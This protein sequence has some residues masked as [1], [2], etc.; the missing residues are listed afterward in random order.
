MRPPG[1]GGAATERLAAATT[2]ALH[3]DIACSR[4]ARDGHE[5]LAAGAGGSGIAD[6]D[7]TEAVRLRHR[8]RD[9]TSGLA[10]A[11]PRV[12]ARPRI[13]SRDGAHGPLAVAQR[14]GARR[15]CR[16]RQVPPHHP[17]PLPGG[18][19]R[20]ERDRGR[21]ASH[22]PAHPRTRGRP[23][24]RGPGL[25]LH[26][27]TDRDARGASSRAP[28]GSAPRSATAPHPDHRTGCAGRRARGCWRRGSWYWRQD[29]ICGD[30]SGGPVPA[31]ST[32]RA[33]ASNA[34]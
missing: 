2:A 10:R 12:R 21:H 30:G 34:G 28:A 25:G 32:S 18:E 15:R 20:S 23:P 16:Q 3:P 4:V 8:R 26:D 24:G 19:R 13:R 31:P 17:A 14:S 11:P 9:R 7:D 5:R 33:A 1:N 29:A 6:G 27:R 22:Q